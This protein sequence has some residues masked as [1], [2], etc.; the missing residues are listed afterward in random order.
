MQLFSVD[1]NMYK[2]FST[3]VATQTSPKTEIQ[4]NQMPLNAGLGF[5]DW[6]FCEENRN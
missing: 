4:L 2:K 5:L 3:G 6:G 1:A